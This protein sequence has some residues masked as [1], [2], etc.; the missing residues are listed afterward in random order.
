MALADDFAAASAWLSSSTLYAWY[1]IATV[2]TVPTSKRPGLFDFQGRAKWDAWHRAGT[3]NDVTDV[4]GQQDAKETA[5]RLYIDCAKQLGWS[6]SEQVP[7]QAALA[8]NADEPRQARGMKGV[9]KMATEE[10]DDTVPMSRLHELAVQGDA[11]A[12]S[13]YIKQAGSSINLDELDSYGFSPLHLATDRGH[14]EAVRILLDAGA[15]PLL[16]DEDGNIAL[17]LARISE[18]DDIVALLS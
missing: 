3:S 4:D 10:I 1:K 14:A 18:H 15:D 2:S 12:I 11:E 5:Q 9:S 17:D 13:I 7:E 16:Q 6:T 8:R